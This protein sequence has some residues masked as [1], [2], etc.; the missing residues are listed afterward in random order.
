MKLI[1]YIISFCVMFIGI[2]IIGESHTFYL[3]NFYNQYDNTTLYLQDNTKS[4][5]M[6]TDIINSAV[7]NKVEVFTFK[8]SQSGV[9]TIEYDIYG[10]IGVEKNINKVSNIFEGKYTSLFLGD[11]N[12]KFN[13]I[14]SI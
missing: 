10:T 6:I 7:N 8:R 3:D 1:K 2:L 5:E 12:F 13:D 11:I 9:K 4:K 14:R